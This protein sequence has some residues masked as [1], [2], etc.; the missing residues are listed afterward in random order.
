MEKKY[1]TGSKPFYCIL[2]GSEIKIGV[3]RDKTAFPQGAG[4][5]GLLCARLRDPVCLRW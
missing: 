1:K 2:N 5:L 4:T 3:L